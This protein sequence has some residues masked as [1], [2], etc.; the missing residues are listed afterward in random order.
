MG[1]F[2]RPAPPPLS[3]EQ[4]EQ[5]DRQIEAVLAPLAYDYLHF[6][7]NTFAEGTLAHRPKRYQLIK[8]PFPP[9]IHGLW[10][11]LAQTDY[12]AVNRSLPK[13]LQRHT[14]LHEIGHILLGHHG[15]DP[16]LQAVLGTLDGLSGADGVLEAGR[17]R[18]TGA[19]RTA[20]PDEIAAERFA[21]CVYDRVR[22]AQRH[23][24]FYGRTPTSN[25]RLQPFTDVLEPRR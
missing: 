1:L 3:R 14:M 17:L 7:V 25:S 5:I 4:F 6:N 24:A 22:Q 20:E 8:L 15:I 12:I 19:D 9:S 21:T 18:E 11:G 23:E 10:C 16:R 2:F 13:P